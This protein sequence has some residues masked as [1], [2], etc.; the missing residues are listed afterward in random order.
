MSGHIIPILKD[1]YLNDLRA[2][3]TT[4][5]MVSTYRDGES[6]SLNPDRIFNETHIRSSTNR[7]DLQVPSAGNRAVG[8]AENAIL[9]HQ[10][11]RDL[12]PLMASDRRLWVYMT[13]D[14][15]F[16]YCQQRFPFSGSGKNESNIIDHWF[17]GRGGLRRNAISRLWWA[18][19][20]TWAPWKQSSKLAEFEKED[21]YYYT[22]V[23]LKNQQIYQDIIERSFGS[24]LS[25]RIA[26]LDVLDRFASRTNKLTKLSARFTKDLNLVASHTDMGAVNVNVIHG[27]MIDLAEKIVASRLT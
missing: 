24:A 8:D 26:A 14:P 2:D 10:Y 9:I 15:F 16:N 4:G 21:E 12:T 22:R 3:A 23:L 19:H 1:S 18:G 7:P 20:L 27:N 5:K 13:H 25:V 17:F 11:L 6:F